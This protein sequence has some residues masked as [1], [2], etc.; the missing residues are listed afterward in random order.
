[1]AVTV[2][3]DETGT[4]AGAPR[5]MIGAVVTMQPTELERVVTLRR[6]ELAADSSL[7][8]DAS[9]RPLFAEEGFHH[10]KDDE[11]IRDRFI[12]TMR[13]LDFR[14]HVCYSR[15]GIKGLADNDLLVVMHY[16]VVRNLLRRYAGQEVNLVFETK[17]DMDSLYGR[18]VK[19]AL[20]SLDTAYAP[21]AS[22]W[23][24]IGD[25][26]LGGL[27]VADYV[28]ALT[29]QHLQ[30]QSGER[31]EAFRVARFARIA[32]HMAHLID[33]DVAAHKRKLARIL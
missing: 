7:W 11:T 23:A 15:R 16:A 10:T 25:K 19:H 32:S 8:P 3:L 31:V 30:Q 14:A 13:T 4:H 9:K 6:Q 12:E 29:E 2:Y 28:L 21:R 27:S 17:S 1:M 33:F 20:D 5:I 26:P 22:V 24:R 18:L